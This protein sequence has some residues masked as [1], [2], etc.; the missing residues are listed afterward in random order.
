V[1]LEDDELDTPNPEAA[2]E[3]SKPTD[4]PGHGP[5]WDVEDGCFVDDD[6][7]PIPLEQEG[8]ASTLAQ[9]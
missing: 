7:R 8:L 4:P 2:A 3:P 5:W 1:I 9:G 6:L